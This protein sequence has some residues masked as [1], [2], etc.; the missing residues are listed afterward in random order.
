MGSNSYVI[1]HHELVEVMFEI[2]HGREYDAYGK[3]FKDDTAKW[4]GVCNHMDNEAEGEYSVSEINESLEEDSD[5]HYSLMY[6]GLKKILVDNKKK[7]LRLV[8]G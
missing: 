1:D 4:N 7:K 8:R 3:K 2:K 6:K 5:G